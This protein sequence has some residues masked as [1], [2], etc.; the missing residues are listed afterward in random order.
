M[1]P[2][3]DPVDNIPQEVISTSSTAAQVLEQALSA[4][5]AHSENA[6]PSENSSNISDPKTTHAIDTNACTVPEQTRS[7][8]RSE[9][10]TNTPRPRTT[11]FVCHHS[12]CGRRF[13]R[14]TSLTNHLKAHQNIKSRSIYRTKRAR[15]RAAANMLANASESKFTVPTPTVPLMRSLDDTTKE[16]PSSITP[17]RQDNPSGVCNEE[18]L[19]SSET[20]IPSPP[21]NERSF[22]PFSEFADYCE[23]SAT[24]S[25]RLV[26]PLSDA[27]P[28]IASFDPGNLPVDLTL[29]ASAYA[30]FTCSPEIPIET[31]AQSDAVLSLEPPG[32]PAE[33]TTA[34]PV[35]DLPEGTRTDTDH[36]LEGENAAPLY[37]GEMVSS[38]LDGAELLAPVL[39][40]S[41]ILE[42]FQPP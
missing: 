42:L 4:I 29:D 10:S 9:H 7:R 38:G 39:S 5:H 40:R 34:C 33:D 27:P 15:L 3:T 20:Y 16:F 6:Q 26:S 21:E 30:T 35:M 14:K 32:N 25:T 31:V 11:E 13:L 28:D 18:V 2:E 22:D 37:T 1:E 17:I 12:D 36:P 24:W 41:S 19:Q 23:Q 8:R